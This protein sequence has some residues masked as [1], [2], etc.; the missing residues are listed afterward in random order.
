M[1]IA[2]T[3][4]GVLKRANI[5]LDGEEAAYGT[6]NTYEDATGNKRRS[7]RR[8]DRSNRRDDRN[9]KREDK[10][11]F[12]P[13]KKE[14][15]PNTI[16]NLTKTPKEILATEKIASGF[17]P[18]NKMTGK[19][20]D[21]T[22]FCDFHNDFGHDTDWCRDLKVA[23]DEAVRTGKLAHLVKGIRSQKPKIEDGKKAPSEGDIGMVGHVGKNYKRRYGITDVP[24]S[25][26]IIF[27]TL[28][29][30]ESLSED[31]LII[32]ARLFER[33]VHRA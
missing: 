26:P 6:G 14:F 30:E 7:D 1:D 11:R 18:P 22:K 25:Q 15:N 12:Q 13:Y 28:E 24:M 17:R 5:W 33:R 10:P 16:A 20:R 9:Q 21:R 31:P 29:D 23:I 8:E 27:P 3:Y 2:D 19:S 4:D 32:N